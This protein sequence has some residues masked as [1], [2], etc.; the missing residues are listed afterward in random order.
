MGTHDVLPPESRRWHDARRARSPTRAARFGYG[1]RGH[2]DRSS[3]SR[4]SSGSASTP[5]SSRKEMYELR[6]Q[7]RARASRCGPRA[8]RRSCGRSCSTARRRRG[9]SGTSR[10]TSA[11]SGRRRAGTAS[12]GSS[13]PRCSASTTPTSTSRSS[14]CSYG[15]Y[16]DLGLSRVRLLLNSMGDAES[17]AAYVDALREL[18]PRPR[19]RRSATSSA[20]GS[21]RTRCASS[22][23]SAPT[24]RTSSSAAPQLTDTSTTRAAT[25]F[26]AVQ[27]GLA[28]ARHRRSSSRPGSCAAS[29]TTRAPR[30]SSQSD[31]LDAAQNALGGGG[32]YDGLAEEMGGPPTP[33]IGFGIGH[34]AAPARVRGRAASCAAPEP[35]ARRV[36]RRRARRRRGRPR[37]LLA[38][39]ART[40]VCAPTARTAAGR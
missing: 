34:R 6:R 13:V 20:S 22:T 18:L 24:G 33:G 37:S 16:R 26:E 39:A 2:A 27:A 40:A 19:R 32:R 15:F 35:R 36:R 21:R 23:R 14:R 5:T 10:R 28:R 1:L 8:R 4:C 29:T 25:H 3:T 11:T 30:S 31:A 7:G 17:R 12:T 9:R 38:R